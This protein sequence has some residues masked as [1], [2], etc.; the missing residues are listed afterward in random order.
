MK[1]GDFLSNEFD[2]D[3]FGWLR[4]IIQRVNSFEK[5]ER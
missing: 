2:S 5:L 4:S 3:T 1:E